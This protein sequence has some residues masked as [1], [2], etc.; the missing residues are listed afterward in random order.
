MPNGEWVAVGAP[1]WANAMGASGMASIRQSS[2]QDGVARSLNS[3]SFRI[4]YRPAVTADMRLVCGGEIFD[5]KQVRHDL[6]ERLWT[7]LVC[8]QGADDG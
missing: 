1:I 3:Y 7:D 8:E 5:I 2:S 6:A 4:R